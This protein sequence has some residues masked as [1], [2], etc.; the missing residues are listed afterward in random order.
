MRKR[1]AA[2]FVSVHRRQ[3]IGNLEIESKSIGATTTTPTAERDRFAA[4][5]RRGEPASS[6][7]S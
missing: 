3:G 7:A 2:A 1:C 6:R 4:E 5:R